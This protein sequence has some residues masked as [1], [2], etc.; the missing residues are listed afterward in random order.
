MLLLSSNC[1]SPII[2]T[3]ITRCELIKKF[4][5]M[6][7]I[8]DINEIRQL[9]IARNIEWTLHVAKRLLQRGIS[10]RDIDSTITSGEIIED[11][12]EDYPFPSCLVMGKT[13]ND[14]VLHLVCAVGDNKL[15]IITAYI[16]NLIEWNEDYRTRRGEK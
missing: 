3:D 2:V 10:A 16:P 11:Y 12:T 9:C 4:A 8:V 13:E 1:F 7:S 14:E 6:V 5:G 15:W